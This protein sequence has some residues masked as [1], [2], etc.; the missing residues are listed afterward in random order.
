MAAGDLYRAEDGEDRLRTG[1]RDFV[2]RA[3][4]DVALP[5]MDGEDG[6][7]RAG[8]AAESVDAGLGIEGNANMMRQ[9]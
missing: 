1:G 2:A 6:R 3:S 7:L 4:P 8:E 9:L 5:A